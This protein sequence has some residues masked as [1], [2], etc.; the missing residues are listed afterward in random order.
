MLC[1][2]LIN[3]FFVSINRTERKGR[4]QCERS[5]ICGAAITEKERGFDYVDVSPGISRLKFPFKM[6]IKS[7]YT[8]Q[9]TV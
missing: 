6:F 7:I 5:I 4:S 2:T 3:Y 1:H 8:V 9:P